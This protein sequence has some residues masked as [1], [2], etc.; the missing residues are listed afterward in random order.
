VSTNTNTAVDTSGLEKPA[1]SS[2]PAPTAGEVEEMTISFM[3]LEPYYDD[4]WNAVT[5]TPVKDDRGAGRAPRT[6]RRYARRVSTPSRPTGRTD[7][8]WG[9]IGTAGLLGLLGLVTAA[10][11]V[12]PQL[13]P[14]QSAAPSALSTATS[15]ATQVAPSPTAGASPTP[16]VPVER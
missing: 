6:R 4:R 5:L 15:P 10:V 2:K 11:V 12:A 13:T 8:R 16:L 3:E 1:A 14:R 9:V 7:R